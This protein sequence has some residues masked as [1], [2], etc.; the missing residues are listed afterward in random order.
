[1]LNDQI[2]KE[3]FQPIKKVRDHRNEKNPHYNKPHSDS[4]K[5]AISAKQRQRYEMLRQIVDNKT[6]T[7]ARVR[8]IIKETI[9][10]YLKKHAIPVDNKKP[11]NIRF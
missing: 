6:V 10:D 8:E 3:T 1:M 7:E 2:N 5:A 9:D 4:A 11:I